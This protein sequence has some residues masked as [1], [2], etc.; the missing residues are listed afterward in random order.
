M[1][2]ALPETMVPKI[3]VTRH[4]AV[5]ETALPDTMVPE[6]RITRHR[7]IKDLRYQTPWCRGPRY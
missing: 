1:L 6:A 5:P 4:H 2:P 3:R 7:A